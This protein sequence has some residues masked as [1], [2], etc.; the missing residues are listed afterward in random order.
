MDERKLL[1]EINEKNKYI[2]KTAIANPEKKCYVLVQCELD[3][4]HIE[5]WEL[6]KQAKE[7]IY[8]L[9]RLTFC[10]K[11]A[12]SELKL[13]WPFFW[14]CMVNKYFTLKFWDRN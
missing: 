3:G 8:F 12:C 9:R 11:T 2:L 6:R 4:R 5:N 13:F 1:K 10:V 14:S 7:M